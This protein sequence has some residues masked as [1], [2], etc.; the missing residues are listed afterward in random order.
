M[1][2]NEVSEKV[3][4]TNPNYFYRIFKKIT[5]VSPSEYR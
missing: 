4:Y 3:G 2:A 5:G 1:K